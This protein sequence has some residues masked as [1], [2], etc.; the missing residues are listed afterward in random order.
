MKKL[1]LLVLMF[2]A[3]MSASAQLKVN[4]NGHV[5]IGT[6]TSDFKPKLFVGESGSFGTDTNFG[7][8]A[9][10]VSQAGK[11]NIAI[12]GSPVTDQSLTT[13]DNYGVFGS[14]FLNHNHGRNY[15]VSGMINFDYNYTYQGGAGIYG[16]N[17]GYL[18]NYPDNLQGYYAG[19]FHGNTNLAGRTTAQEIYTP[20]DA[21]LSEN[22][23]FIGENNR[24]GS[25]MLDNLLKMNVLEFNMKNSLTM[26]APDNQEEMAEEVR[27][28]YEYM[29]KDEEELFSRRH[30]GLSAQELQEIYPNL[31]LKGQDGYLYINYQEMV[32]VLIRSIQELKQEL[33]DMKGENRD[34]MMSRGAIP[35]TVSAIQASG[36]VLY[37]N[38]PNP[39]KEQTTIR[40]QLADDAQNAAICIFDMTGKMLKKLPVSL[41]DTSVKING[42]ELGEGMFL[43]TLIVNGR[44]IDTKR[45]IITR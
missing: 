36:N 24:D 26:K 1:G 15:G 14:T 23:E 20:A 37:Q 31:V 38:S 39:F 6:T 43:Y 4:N 11:K 34:V 28:A 12:K 10:M 18:Y 35:T 19:Y 32:P 7:L 41:G 33:D 29:K 17:Y 9:Q 3:I 30:F 44:E 25:Q 40:F 45:M 13:D 8:A 21:R 5:S 2:F 22:V 42:W 27:Q 16:T